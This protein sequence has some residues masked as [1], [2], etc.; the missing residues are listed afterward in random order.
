MAVTVKPTVVMARFDTEKLRSWKSVSGTSGS[1]VVRACC[2]TNSPSTSTPAP[3]T[4]QTVIGP[5]I[6]PQS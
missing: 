5:Q 6:T 1:E 4:D 3:I 2:H